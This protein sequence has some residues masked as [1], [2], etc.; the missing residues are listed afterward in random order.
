MHTEIH[1]HTH[2]QADLHPHTHRRTNMH[3]HTQR[4]RERDKEWECAYAVPTGANEEPETSMVVAL[5][6]SLLKRRTWPIG[7][8]AYSHTEMNN[9]LCI[10]PAHAV[11][12]F[13]RA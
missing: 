4:E 9:K 6:P 11:S 12:R 13:V 1:R 8:H 3:T 2:I 10:D 5:F 7:Q